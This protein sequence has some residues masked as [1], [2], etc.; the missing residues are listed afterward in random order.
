MDRRSRT[1]NRF[2]YAD[3]R[4]DSPNVLTPIRRTDCRHR[5]LT[6]DSDIRRAVRPS[7]SSGLPRGRS[8]GSSP[9]VRLGRISRG[10]ECLPNVHV[11]LTKHQLAQSD[12]SIRKV[13]YQNIFSNIDFYRLTIS[14]YASSVPEESRGPQVAD[15]CKK[16]SKARDREV[17]LLLSFNGD[18]LWATTG[19][20]GFLPEHETKPNPV[21]LETL[22]THGDL[23]TSD[24]QDSIRKFR[25]AHRLASSLCS[26]YSGPWVQH[27]WSSESV[28]IIPNR[29]GRPVEMLDEAYVTCAFNINGRQ[30][31]TPSVPFQ[32]TNSTETCPRF[33]LSLAQLLVDIANGERS[34]RSSSQDDFRSWYS[35]LVAEVRRNMDDQLMGSYWRAIQGCLLYLEN[36]ENH[37]QGSLDEKLRAREVIY[38]HVVYHLQEN[39]N[40]WREQ[41]EARSVEEAENGSETSQPHGHAQRIVDQQ[42]IEHGLLATATSPRPRAG[43]TVETKFTLWSN[44]D[45][46]YTIMCANS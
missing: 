36:Y 14:S 34:H 20:R 13:R 37:G 23:K 32:D 1:Q 31:H 30:I 9:I 44:H 25:F 18:R 28:Q 16:I 6:T 3:R 24:L 43:P 17:P 2:E 39:L 42:H 41:Q 22:L 12:M 45:D 15:I 8:W 27:D 21:D 7:G 11:L 33:L 10:E 29:N 26:L 38:E 4:V 35:L 40:F 19:P 46:N 5:Q